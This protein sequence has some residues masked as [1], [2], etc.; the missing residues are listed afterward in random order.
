MAADLAIVDYGC[1][2]IR[3]LINAF[4][5]NGAN[6]ELVSDPDKIAGFDKLVLPGVGS[7][8]AAMDK[9][10]LSGFDQALND[11]K[12]SGKPVLGICLG[13]QLM[14][15]S[16]DEIPSSFEG[17]EIAGLAWVDAKVEHLS[18]GHRQALKVPHMGWNELSF[19]AQSALFEGLEEGTDVY[20]VH[21][22]AVQCNDPEDIVTV[23]HYGID[24]VSCF[25]SDNVMGMQFHPEK[26]HR[27]G[28]RIIENFVSMDR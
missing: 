6:P 3:S 7:F 24:F 4:R 11:Y 2:N 10:K 12:Q 14:C 17:S 21:S 13:M 23:S 25:V 1:G 9:L 27:A 22:H 26:S 19:R 15:T 18:K 8:G 16:S 28:L 5:F 20:F